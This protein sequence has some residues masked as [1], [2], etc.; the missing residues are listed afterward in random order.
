MMIHNG[1]G[2]TAGPDDHDDD[3]AGRDGLRG[4]GWPEMAY[5]SIRAINHLTNTSLPVPAPVLYDVLGN[6]K[7]VGYLL[8]QA[9]VQLG[10][11]LERSLSVYDVYDHAREPRVSVATAQRLL[12]EAATKARDLGALLEEAQTTINSQGYRRGNPDP[13]AQP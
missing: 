8:P 13:Q 12:V 5:E 4:V 10:N 2:L 3:D 11:G 1:R 9:L 7:G 6:L